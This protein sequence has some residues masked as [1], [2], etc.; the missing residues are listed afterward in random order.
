MFAFS[1]QLLA[2]AEVILL[3]YIISTLK[4][5]SGIHTHMSREQEVYFRTHKFCCCCFCISR[6]L[7]LDLIVTELKKLCIAD[8]TLNL[9]LEI[10][11]HILYQEMLLLHY[12]LQIVP[13]YN[14]YFNALRPKK[15]GI[16][17]VRL[18]YIEW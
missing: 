9:N 18:F 4:S 8:E 5:Y 14:P 13:N 2:S 12:L 11:S 16:I 17:L 7:A 1:L 3:G 15:C 6:K 10:K